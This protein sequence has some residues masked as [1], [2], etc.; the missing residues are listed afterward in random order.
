VY[1]RIF[2]PKRKEEGSWIKLLNDELHNVYS[3]PTNVRVIKTRKLRWAGDVAQMGR[4]LQ[5]F[6]W[7]ARRKDTTG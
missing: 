5:D 6:G 7:K 4:Y 2:G 3:S 1:R